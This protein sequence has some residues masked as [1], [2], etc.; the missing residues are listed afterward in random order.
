MAK[1]VKLKDV[2]TLIWE[3]VKITE[4]QGETGCP[5]IFIVGSGLQSSG[6]GCIKCLDNKIW[7]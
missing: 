3:T 7:V 1:I 4:E 2:I 6:R 5:Y